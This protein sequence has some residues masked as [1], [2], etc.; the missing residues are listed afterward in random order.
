MNRALVAT[1]QRVRP[2]WVMSSKALAV[3]PDSVKQIKQIGAVTANWFPDDLQ[4]FDWL[5]QAV[6]VYDYLFS[7]DSYT[8]AALQA[9]DAHNV[10]YLPL[11]C[12]PAVHRS[13]T[14]TPAERQRYECDVAFV[15]AP[16]PE[17]IE[18]LCALREFDLKIWGYDGWLKSDLADCYQ[19]VIDNDEPLVRL[20]NACRIVVNIHFGSAAHGANYRVFEASGCGAFQLVSFRQ[21]IPNLFEIGQEIV[22]FDKPEDLRD[23]V[24]YYLDH[25]DERMAIA[26]ASQ[27]R[28]YREHTVVQ[29]VRQMQ[30][31]C[32]GATA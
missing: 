5:Q 28:A 31:I 11:A 18:A 12:D 29:R 26:R 19:G 2:A 30:Q 25:L 3:T 23:K 24:A 16:Y 10:Y 27:A 20:Y 7:F 32:L 22:T 9:Q 1:A 15:G 8:V 6:K 13:V 4:H 14:L 17:R 21:D